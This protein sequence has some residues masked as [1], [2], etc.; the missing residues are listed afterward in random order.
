M[1]RHLRP[2]YFV[3]AFLVKRAADG[4]VVGGG[5]VPG[6]DFAGAVEMLHRLDADETLAHFA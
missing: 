5:A 1:L 6:S 2:D 4:N 3:T